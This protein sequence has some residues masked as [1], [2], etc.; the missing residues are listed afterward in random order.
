MLFPIRLEGNYGEMQIGYLDSRGNV[1]FNVRAESAFGPYDLTAAIK[2]CGRVAIM[3]KE[4]N[5]VL[6]THGQ[7]ADGPHFGR[8]IAGIKSADDYCYG[9]LDAAGNWQVEAKF[10]DLICWDGKFFSAK[11]EMFGEYSLYDARGKVL[12]ENY[13]L[14]GSLVSEELIVAD[15]AKDRKGRRG[16]RK[17]NGDWQ[18]KPRFDSATPFVKGRSF[19]TEGL[20]KARRAGIIDINGKWLHQFPKKVQGFCDEV[21]ENVIGVYQGK[22]SG[23]MNLEGDLLCEGEWNPMDGKVIGGVIPTLK[24]KG[25]KY[26]LMDIQ[27]NWRVKPEYET[28]VA[29]V[30]PF[31]AFRRDPVGFDEIVVANTS[32]SI[33]WDG[34]AAL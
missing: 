21:S 4:G 33:L 7:I 9:L 24:F 6:D 10:F 15:L 20:G 1:Q 19:V 13:A 14:V 27:G 30:G 29:Q 31:V 3:S 2:H 25:K 23:L 26:G 28:V 11:L 32:G 22:T 8:F 17:L 5:R 34:P 16:F 18:I 12:L